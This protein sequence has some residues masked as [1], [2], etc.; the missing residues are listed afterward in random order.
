MDAVFNLSMA[1][2][3][4]GGIGMIFSIIFEISDK[5]ESNRMDKKEDKNE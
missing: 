2:I 4:A 5:M 3:L 1:L